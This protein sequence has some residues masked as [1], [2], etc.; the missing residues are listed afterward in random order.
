MDECGTLTHLGVT[1]AETRTLT[2]SLC[3]CSS[4]FSAPRS[5]AVAIVTQLCEDSLTPV[6]CESSSKENPSFCH[7]RNTSLTVMGCRQKMWPQRLG[8][9]VTA[10]VVLCGTAD[11][12][13]LS[14]SSTPAFS[15]APSRKAEDLLGKAEK[16]ASDVEGIVKANQRLLS[17]VGGT[18]LLLHG[19]AFSTSILFLQ[20]FRSAGLPIMQRGYR[21]SMNGLLCKHS[22]RLCHRPCSAS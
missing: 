21:T 15:A 13:N 20:S 12:L 1:C 10:L 8:R 16:L 5:L 2:I 11:A 17:A 18:V 22:H 14:F 19:Q 3:N 9:L 7:G 4:L 6:E